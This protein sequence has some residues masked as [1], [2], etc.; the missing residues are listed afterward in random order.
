MQFTDPNAHFASSD[1]NKAITIYGAGPAASPLTTSIIAVN[2]ATSVALGFEA[3]TAISGT[4]GYT[5]GTMLQGSTGTATA[6]SKTFTDPNASFVSGNV[7][8]DIVIT[9]AGNLGCLTRHHHRRGQLAHQHHLGH[10]G[11]HLGLGLRPLRLRHPDPGH[12]QRF[13]HRALRAHLRH[14]VQRLH[15][16]AR[17]D[18]DQRELQRRRLLQRRTQLQPRQ[19]R[20][21]IDHRF[22]HDGLWNRYNPADGQRGQ[23]RQ[24]ARGRD[25]HGH[26]DR[27][28]VRLGLDHG[29]LR[30][31]PRA[32]R[33]T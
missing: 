14:L 20:R 2:S 13:V 8:D 29:R 21:R 6:A 9:G 12:H 24:R 19:R 30:L 26:G 27:H 32:P 4:A 22:L 3:S 11:A 33:S 25:Q 7:G 17:H 10:R 1:L 31:R 16:R 15:R 23:P 28:R 5:Y 18:L